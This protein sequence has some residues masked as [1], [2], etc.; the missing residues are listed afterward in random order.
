MCDSPQLT[1]HY[2]FVSFQ[3]CG[4]E[5][6]RREMNGDHPANEQDGRRERTDNDR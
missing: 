2:T 3:E 5:K 1:Q 4:R 6:N